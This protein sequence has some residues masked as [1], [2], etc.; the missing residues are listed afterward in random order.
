MPCFAATAAI[1]GSERKAARPSGAHELGPDS[2]L[3][4]IGPQRLLLEAR[5]QLD[6]VDGGRDA[7]LAD[8]PL[9]M[10]AV[11]I[12]DAD[13]ANAS[14]LPE[15]DQRLPGLHVKAGARPGPVDEIEVDWLAPES[16]RA[17][18]EGAKGIVEAVVAIAEFGRDE[19][20][21]AVAQRL[22]H[23]FLVAVHRGRVDE[24][25]AVGDRLPHDVGRGASRGLKDAQPELRHR[26]AVVEG[27]HRVI[28]QGSLLGRFAIG[29]VSPSAM[30]RRKR[31]SARRRRRR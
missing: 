13:R 24:A 8:D 20:V 15:T 21:P 6:L 23:P 28:R 18:V 4:V 12:R 7:G 10:V 19:H 2:A 11:E 16:P 26:D 27:D 17:E 3:A 22:A 14:V 29:R 30:R 31:D 25:I 9:Q 5:V 1:V